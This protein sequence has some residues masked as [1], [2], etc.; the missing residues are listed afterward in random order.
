MQSL[1]KIQRNSPTLEARPQIPGRCG[2]TVRVGA[3]IILLMA[4]L[5]FAAAQS[6]ARADDAKCQSVAVERPCVTF[7]QWLMGSRN[8]ETSQPHPQEPSD[9]AAPQLWQ[10]APPQALE[11]RMAEPQRASKSPPS[12][13]SP[14][15]LGSV[16]HRHDGQ[17][18]S[19][20]GPVAR[21]NPRTAKAAA[22]AH[23]VRSDP[24][25]GA[26]P[27]TPRLSDPA[28]LPPAAARGIRQDGS[29]ELTKHGPADALPPAANQDNGSAA[30]SALPDGSPEAKDTRPAGAGPSATETPSAPPSTIETP[31]PTTSAIETPG[32][33][34]TPNAAISSLEPTN[35]PPSAVPP[36]AQLAPESFATLLDSGRRLTSF[37]FPIEIGQHIPDD[38]NLAV[39]PTEVVAQR[40]ELGGR[41]FIIVGQKVVVA[42]PNTRQIVQIF[43]PAL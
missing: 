18:L 14:V 10:P 23:L 43:G 36:T 1:R 5:G 30:H 13:K 25:K 42:D 29:I 12:S 21:P 6:P 28:A 4:A 22:P 3:L 15:R 7:F 39:I 41:F 16:H 32:A 9:A 17:I 20:V 33:V 38:V 11:S 35:S 27:T 40:P 24:G 31:G 37:D 8:R 26:V 34:V 19:F 2:P